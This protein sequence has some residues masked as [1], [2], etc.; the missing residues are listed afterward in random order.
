MRSSTSL[1]GLLKSTKLISSS[2]DVSSDCATLASCAF[3][4]GVMPSSK[5]TMKTALMNKMLNGDGAIMNVELWDKSF[6]V[7]TLV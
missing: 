7:K 3:T 2:Y 1:P 5:P 4:T 6:G